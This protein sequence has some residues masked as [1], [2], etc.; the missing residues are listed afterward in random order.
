VSTF[1]GTGEPLKFS[2]GIKELHGR[3][4][5]N[6]QVLEQKEFHVSPEVSEQGEKIAVPF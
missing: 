5:A 4:I 3:V 2:K 6:H 1:A